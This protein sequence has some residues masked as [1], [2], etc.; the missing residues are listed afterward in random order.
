[1]LS[2][3]R[4]IIIICTNLCVWWGCI[5]IQFVQV[6]M[7]FPLQINYKWMS[8]IKDMKTPTLHL[9]GWLQLILNIFGWRLF[10]W[11]TCRHT[12]SLVLVGSNYLVGWND[13]TKSKLMK[14]FTTWNYGT[15]KC[16]L[17]HD[18]VRQNIVHITGRMWKCQRNHQPD[19]IQK[20]WSTLNNL[21]IW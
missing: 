7:D 8:S 3:T 19:N 5:F 17:W 20:I 12:C 10:S 1:M 6:W 21:M 18:L 14:K 4:L 2:L 13:C 9:D 11:Y 16:I 15:Q